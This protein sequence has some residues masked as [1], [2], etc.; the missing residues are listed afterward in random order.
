MSFLTSRALP[1]LPAV[2]LMSTAAFNGI[3]ERHFFLGPKR[4]MAVQDVRWREKDLCSSTSLY[5]A[6]LYTIAMVCPLFATRKNRTHTQQWQCPR[7]VQAQFGVNG[8]NP[9]SKEQT[10]EQLWLQGRGVRGDAV[11]SQAFLSP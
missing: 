1:L 5:S 11:S 8:L 9:K 2:I 10:A 3:L 6:S 4:C 7:K